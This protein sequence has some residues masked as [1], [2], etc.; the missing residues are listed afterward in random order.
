M[1]HTK[2]WLAKAFLAQYMKHEAKQIARKK[3]T[4]MKIPVARTDKVGMSFFEKNFC[5]CKK[6]TVKV[7]FEIISSKAS[8][9]QVKNANFPNLV[10]SSKYIVFEK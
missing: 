4:S 5:C 10:V 9:Q 1:I 8:F 3:N 6:N 2:S 7:A